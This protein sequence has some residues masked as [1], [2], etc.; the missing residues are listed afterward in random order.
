MPVFIRWLRPIMAVSIASLIAWLLFPLARGAPTLLL[1][2]SV[3]ITSWQAGL[4]GGLVSATL[5]IAALN[6]FFIPPFGFSLRP[7]ELLETFIFAVFAVV[8][9]KVA[10]DRR[11]TQQRVLA[12]NEQ[13]EDKV[14]ART[15]ELV[16]ANR[17]LQ[18][19][20]RGISHDLREPLRMMTAYSQL[21]SRRSRDGRLDEGELEMLDYISAGGERMD[22][23]I[24]DLLTYSTALQS[25]SP[26][27]KVDVR[28]TIESAL[29]N[30]RTSILES[31]ATVSF[32][33]LPHVKGVESELIRLFQ[34]LIGNALKYR[35]S[36]T[37]PHIQI[38]AQ[39]QGPEWLFTIADN[40]LG[41][42]PELS[43]IIFGVF[44]RLHQ[45]ESAGTGVGLALCRRITEQHGGRI[46]AN[47]NAGEGA[48]FY[49][50][51]PDADA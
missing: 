32:D 11:R 31:A 43:E 34:N 23:M 15:A 12:A 8:T 13:L 19:F 5:A 6:A 24:A 39:R 20:A 37:P 21:L 38:T 22:R 3:L 33:S 1:F 36:N 40:G 47:G 49:L 42:K 48:T 4:A 16:Q 29:Q 9:S 2:S 51:L 35:K 26:L 10:S 45:N 27:Y 50:T 17:Q 28:H 14:A 41:F 18:E 44:K 46:W 30:L 25:Q 7:E